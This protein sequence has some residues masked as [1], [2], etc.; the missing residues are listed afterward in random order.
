[1]KWLEES[2]A[3]GKQGRYIVKTMEELDRM[4]DG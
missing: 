4:A 1:M 2:I 3:Q